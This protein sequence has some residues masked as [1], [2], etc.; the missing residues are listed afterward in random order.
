VGKPE[1]KI[2]LGNPSHGS[3][4]VNKVGVREMGWADMN[5]IYL[6]NYK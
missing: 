1:G 3:M 4:Y 6:L 5:W 2:S